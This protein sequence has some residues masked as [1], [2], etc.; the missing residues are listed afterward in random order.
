M[1]LSSDGIATNPL[2]PCGACSEWLLKLGEQ[3]PSFRVVTYTS[4]ELD[5]VSPSFTSHP[6][7]S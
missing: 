3:N 1:P 2:R 5:E 4:L 7:L 6:S